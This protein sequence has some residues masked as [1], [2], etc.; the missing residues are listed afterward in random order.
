MDKN[1]KIEHRFYITFINQ[2]CSYLSAIWLFISDSKK[3]LDICVSQFNSS[4]PKHKI[5]FQVTVLI[6]SVVDLLNFFYRIIETFD[7]V[8]KCLI[9]NWLFWKHTNERQWF[10]SIQLEFELH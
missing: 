1:E 3:C 2:N 5:S 9:E 7:E 10:P 8:L 6:E 4:C